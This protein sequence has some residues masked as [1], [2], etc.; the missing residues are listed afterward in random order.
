MYVGLNIVSGVKVPVF[1]EFNFIVGAS[2]SRK[3][4]TA[5]RDRKNRGRFLF[6]HSASF[7]T[8]EIERNKS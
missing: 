3:H 4:N 7:K 8:I 6:V 2:T 1:A 5:E